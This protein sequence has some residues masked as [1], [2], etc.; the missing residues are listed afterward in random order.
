MTGDKLLPQDEAEEDDSPYP[1]LEEVETMASEPIYARRKKVTASYLLASQH[2]NDQSTETCYSLDSL[3][4]NVIKPL[5]ELKEDGAVIGESHLVLL[6][7]AK[8][9]IAC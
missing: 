7:M 1:T 5:Y 9:V 4:T 6:S 8:V 3:P 2:G